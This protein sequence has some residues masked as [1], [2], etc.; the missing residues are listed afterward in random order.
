VPLIAAVAIAVTGRAAGRLGLALAVGLTGYWLAFAVYV[1]LRPRLQRPDWRDLAAEIGP[2]K[3][4]RE[5]VTSGQA[6]VPLRYYLPGRTVELH[7]PHP[8]IPVSEV[9]VVAIGVPPK[10]SG[11]GLPPPFRPAGQQRAKTVTLT[12]YRAARPVPVP[13]HE[14]LDHY[15]GFISRD[16]LAQGVAPP[17]PPRRG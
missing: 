14:L 1:D 13:W 10:Q 9:D 8:P 3:L 5:I 6:T 12:R 7:A 4:P 2:A 11:T 16:V 17:Q 15:T